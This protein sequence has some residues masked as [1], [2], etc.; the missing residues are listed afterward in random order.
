[1]P[2]A[3][4]K[5]GT[6]LFQSIVTIQNFFVDASI[7]EDGALLEV[8]DAQRLTFSD[9][10]LLSR[11]EYP[12]ALRARAGRQVSLKVVYDAARFDREA[13]ARL[14]VHYQTLLEGITAQ[15]DAPAGRPAAP[16]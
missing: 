2:G 15:P 7:H 13:I 16:A 12:L 14:A 6:P 9:T 1:M 10:R 3:T 5:P 8:G 4:Y 11:S